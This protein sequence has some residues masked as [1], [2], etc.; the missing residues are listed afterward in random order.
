MSWDAKMIGRALSTDFLNRKCV[1]L[2]PNTTWPGAECDVLGVTMDLRVIDIEIKISRADFKADASKGKWWHTDWTTWE[3]TRGNPARTRLLWPRRVW[4]HYFAMPADIWKPELVECL[5][6]PACGVLLLTERAGRK[7]SPP[8]LDVQC[9]RR[10]RPNK[11][12]ERLQPEHVID[13]ARLANLRMWDAY[14]DV[15]RARADAAKVLSVR[16]AA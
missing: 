8:L 15:E 9:V 12:A 13:V 16:E 5:P 4:K 10:S 3:Q 11:E 14:G 7:H 2:V 1:L 6:S